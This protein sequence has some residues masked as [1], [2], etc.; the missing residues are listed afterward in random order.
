MSKFFKWFPLNSFYHLAPSRADA[1]SGTLKAVGL[2]ERGGLGASGALMVVGGPSMMHLPP[3]W[4][5]G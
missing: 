1:L 4:W 2:K 3:P 5:K